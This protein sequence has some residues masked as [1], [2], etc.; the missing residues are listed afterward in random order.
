MTNP[1]IVDPQTDQAAL[2]SEPRLYG[3]AVAEVERIDTHGA[4]VYLGGDR[5]LKLKRAVDYPYMDLSTVALRERACREELVLNRRTAA[6][7]YRGVAAIVRRPDG[8]VVLRPDG[9]GLDRT[10]VIDWVV[11]MNRFDQSRQLD[12][13][14]S[15]G[16]LDAPVI[17]ALADGLADFHAHAAP[18]GRDNLEAMGWVVR[19][20][21][22]ELKEM[23][24]TVL[25]ADR[26]AKLVRRTDQAFERHRDTLAGRTG[27][28]WVRRCHGDLHLRNI[29]LLEDGPAPFDAIDFNDALAEVDTLYDLAFLIMDLD[30]RGFRAHANR[31]F[32]RY[33]IRLGDLSGLSL[34]PLYLAIR[35]TVRAKISASLALTLDDRAAARA[36]RTEAATYLDRAIA[37]LAEWPARLVVVGGLSGTGKTTVARALAPDLD[38]CPGALHLR[39]DAV[40]KTL[41]GVPEETRLTAEHYTGAWH[42]RTFAALHRHARTALEAGRAVVLD[43]VYGRPADRAEVETLARAVGV[44]FQGIWLETDLETRIDRVSDR[45]KD[46]SDADAA[47][48]ARQAG[49][50]TEPV[51]WPTVP[52]G[53][54]VSA[55]VAAARAV[56]G[57]LPVDP[58]N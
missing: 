32:A 1:H 35:A 7:L 19:D 5:V 55:V 24:G 57:G 37:Y 56:L 44:P 20:N 46:A 51:G 8:G 38:S 58:R 2:L 50:I 53:G 11:D 36:A 13:L 33:L 18:V 28:G 52:A 34:L 27:R 30:F 25:P 47:V 21:A 31:L 48:A 4:R 26:V 9:P 16:A 12:R 6:G 14:A 54:D 49:W 40:R 17:D 45:A 3:P 23:T 15:A 41:A 42:A 10:T 39:S 22:A 43:G 29:V